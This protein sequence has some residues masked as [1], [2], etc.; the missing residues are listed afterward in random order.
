L[1]NISPLFHSRKFDVRPSSFPFISGDT[2]RSRSEIVV[3]RGQWFRNPGVVS[4]TIFAE[5]DEI[6]SERFQ[7][8][9][10]RFVRRSGWPDPRI[11]VHNGDHLPNVASFRRLSDI[12]VQ[13]FAVNVVSPDWPV[14]PVPIGLENLHYQK[15]GRVDL[16]ASATFRSDSGSADRPRNIGMS[17]RT[18]T[19]PT[20]RVPAR[21]ILESHGIRFQEP[22]LTPA[23]YVS[24]VC[25]S[26]FIISPPGNGNDCHRTWEAIYLGAIPI[27]LKA[28]L[29]HQLA[30]NLP[31]WAVDS[32]HEVAKLT[33]TQLERKFNELSQRDSSGA[34][35]D[36]W[37]KKIFAGEKVE[38]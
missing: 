34:F 35:A 8:R 12:F 16:F 2:F 10:E 5:A 27:V 18:G 31:I 37:F 7:R 13:V 6:D 24:W 4:R 17:F 22:T 11:I 23:E 20:I 19:N 30:D 26:K 15:N 9:L 3:E 21:E 36:Y 38:S 32:W 1:R 29:S 14:T 25:Q 33:P 28:Y